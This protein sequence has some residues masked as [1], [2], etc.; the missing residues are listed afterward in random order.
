MSELTFERLRWPLAIVLVVI[1]GFFLLPRDADSDP[2]ATAATATPTPTIAVGE[3]G[4]EIT[5]TETPPPPEPT[6]TATPAPTPSPTPR[7][8]PTPA[9]T[10]PPLAAQGFSAQVLAC[11]SISGSTCNGQLGT[12][13]AGAGSFTALVRFTDARAGDTVNAVLSGPAGTIPGGAY[14][15]QGGGDGYYYSMFSAGGLPAGDYTLT[16]T[17]NGAEVAETT[18]TKASG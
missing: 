7:P 8:T 2:A 14:T 10:P 18:F 16:A 9:P 17:F 12:L 6:P 3:P 13:P 4:G 15:L 11:Q 5:S 1:A